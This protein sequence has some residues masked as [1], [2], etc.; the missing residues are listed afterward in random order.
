MVRF[1]SLILAALLGASAAGYAADPS[2]A[3]VPQVQAPLTL[4]AL[5]AKL[6]ATGASPAGKAVEMEILARFNKSGSDTAD[7][8]LSWAA[9]AIEAERY[10]HA[11]DILDQV[12]VMKP[13]FAE[14][15]NKR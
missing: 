6:A 14:A 5:F 10:Q 15:W 11:L 4:D 7:L 3:P 8:L 13:G 2:A 12:I 1:F 9:Q